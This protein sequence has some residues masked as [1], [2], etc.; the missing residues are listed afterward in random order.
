MKLHLEFFFEVDRA[1]QKGTLF[2]FDEVGD[3][4]PENLRVVEK[5][6]LD[7]FGNPLGSV[8]NKYVKC[9]MCSRDV[10]ATK[11]A[12]HLHKC[13][14]G[15]RNSSRAASARIASKANLMP[16]SQNS[17]DF[18][19]LGD[20]GSLDGFDDD[21]DWRN[22]PN[23]NSSKH[24]NKKRKNVTNSSNNG[25]SPRVQ[26]SSKNSAV[27]SIAEVSQSKQ[28]EEMHWNSVASEGLSKNYIDSKLSMSKRSGKKPG[29]SSSS[30]KKNKKKQH[31]KSGYD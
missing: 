18:G 28:G 31:Q 2:L 19:Q 5:D 6:G 15:G 22:E 27:K 17:S 25:N 30:L 4:V 12:P 3:K 13:M 29:K 20:G 1:Y 9:P 23:Q 11:Y 8:K 10:G 16:S 21:L 26:P 7:I 24:K 14:L